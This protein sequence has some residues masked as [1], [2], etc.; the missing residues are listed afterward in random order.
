MD[1]SWINT[2]PEP[3]RTILIGAA[4]DFAGGLASD[5]A[6]RLLDAAGYQVKKRFRSEPQQDALNQAMAEALL[7]T[8]SA[9]TDDPDLMAHYLTLF[10]EWSARDAVAGELSQ[11]I[12]PRPDAEIDLDLLAA[13]FE[14]SG[15]DP[16][17]LGGDVVF[18]NVVAQ[19]VSSFY[20]AAARQPTLQGQIE[21]GLLRGIAERAEEQVE[22]LQR[23]ADSLERQ[24]GKPGPTTTVKINGDRNLV[25]T[26]RVGRDLIVVDGNLVQNTGGDETDP[27]ALRQ[28]Y[29]NRV[30]EQTQ[31]LQL[32]G[33][34]PK[35]AQDATARTGLALAAVYTGLMTQ[36]SEQELG[37]RGQIDPAREMRRLSAVELLNREPRLVLL[38]DPGSGKTHLCQLRG[39]VP[40][41]R[42]AGAERRQPGRC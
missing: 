16:D 34:D 12:D 33:V 28:A 5:I 6:G 1:P 17:L 32:T 14:A 31:T 23:V 9:Q 37:R 3:L 10:G 21:I 8:V 22:L 18:Q 2:I 4:G 27:Q 15:Y 35:A 39:A 40:G 41:R 29:L 42:G 36:Q 20:D 24:P 7:V 13:E 26:G 11:V 25:M 19:F 38:G 30:L